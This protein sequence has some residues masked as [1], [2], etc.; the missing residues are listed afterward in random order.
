[1]RRQQP[2]LQEGAVRLREQLQGV[3]AGHFRKGN[4]AQN[5]LVRQGQVQP[6]HLGKY[7]GQRPDGP[8]G[9]DHRV[10]LHSQVRTNQRLVRIQGA[11]EVH[12]GSS[13][14]RPAYLPG[15]AWKIYNWR[16]GSLTRLI[17]VK[18]RQSNRSK[19]PR[20]FL[21]G[22]SQPTAPPIVCERKSFLNR[23]SLSTGTSPI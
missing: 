2:V 15:A 16:K 21:P 11:T 20:C 9:V 22:I 4:P 8:Q 19:V 13:Q 5:R 14:T 6:L 12:R 1:M 10:H 3:Q 18:T 23:S 7:T 17:N